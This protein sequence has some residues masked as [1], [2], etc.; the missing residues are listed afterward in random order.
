MLEGVFFWCFVFSL[1]SLFLFTRSGRR[2]GGESE[3]SVMDGWVWERCCCCCCCCFAWGSAFSFFVL[4]VGRKECEC[5]FRRG[6]ELFRARAEMKVWW[7][8][9]AGD[10][11][12]GSGV[13]GVWFVLGQWH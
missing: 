9:D 7:W 6:V 12:G 3:A 4:S 11:K 13:D 10:E 2:G 1:F 5:K 8:R